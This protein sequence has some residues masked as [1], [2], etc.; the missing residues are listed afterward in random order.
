MAVTVRPLEAGDRAQWE[1]LWQAYLTF[2][3]SEVSAEVTETLWQRLLTP[4]EGHDGFCACD[5]DGRLIGITH[6]LLHASTWS[7]N[8][9]C[10]LEDLYVDANARSSGAG[11]ALIKAVGDDAAKRG[12]TRLYLHTEETNARARGLYNKVMMLSDFVQYRLALDGTPLD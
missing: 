5:A 9:Y 1:P 4:G 8:G 11:R 7:I 3:R 10:Y 12:A 6:Y 2:Y